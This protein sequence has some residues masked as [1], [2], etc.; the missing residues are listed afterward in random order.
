MLD[1]LREL[2]DTDRLGVVDVEESE[3]LLEVYESLFYFVWNHY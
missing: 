1:C 3:T 2:I